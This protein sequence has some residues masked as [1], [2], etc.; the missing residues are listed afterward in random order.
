VEL[1]TSISRGAKEYQTLGIVTTLSAVHLQSAAYCL[2]V[3]RQSVHRLDIGGVTQHCV[4]LRYSRPLYT[5]VYRVFSSGP[6]ARYTD[7]FIELSP[8]TERSG[9]SFERPSCW[10]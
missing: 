3:M 8:L 10:G 2:S 4:I 6:H 9:Q 1:L 5:A 7:G